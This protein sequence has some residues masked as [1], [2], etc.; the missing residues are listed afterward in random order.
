MPTSMSVR[1]S[2]SST[3]DRSRSHPSPS[4]NPPSR[5]SS[6]P[7]PGRPSGNRKQTIKRSCAHTREWGGTD[8]GDHLY[9]LASEHEAV[10]PLKEPYYR[11][12]QYAAL[13]PALPR[14]RPEL[15][16]AD[17]R[18]GRRLYRVPD[19]G[20]GCDECDVHLRLLRHPGHLG[21]AVRLS[22]GDP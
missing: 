20:H 22:K 4:T 11:Q 21:Q 1:S 6:S 17:A 12:Y 13:L 19:P 18:D 7:S 14:L 2:R 5:M 8:H 3:R 15:R 16:G 10:Y 9:H